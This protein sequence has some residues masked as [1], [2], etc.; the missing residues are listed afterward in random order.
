MSAKKHDN[1]DEHADGIVE[2]RKQVPPLYFKILFYALIIWAIGFS[3]YYLLSGWSSEK[4]FDKKMTAYQQTYTQAAPASAAAATPAATSTGI[5]AVNIYNA[6]CAS[7]HGTGGS[8]GF[9]TDL[10][11]NY[12]YG[13]DATS[14]R[15]SIANGRGSMM[16]G[17]ADTLSAAEIDALA[18]YLLNL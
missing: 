12:S 10:S 15:T 2:D 13:K 16:P 18:N 17:F 6:N 11:G 8:G 9:A 5:H 3:A 14:I 7:C 1:H 4:E